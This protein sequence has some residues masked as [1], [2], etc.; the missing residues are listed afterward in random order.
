MSLNTMHDLLV[1]ELRDLY[2]AEGQVLKA[3]PTMAEKAN[4]RSLVSALT[5]HLHETEEH[6]TRLEECFELLAVSSKGKRCKGM[7]GLLT[8]A[9]ELVGEA[10]NSEV[11]DAAIISA[12]QKVEHYEICGYGT[13]CAF[14]ERLELSEVASLLQQILEE[15]SAANERLSEIAEAEVNV[16]TVETN[17]EPAEAEE[18]TAEG[19]RSKPKSRSPQRATGSRKRS[20]ASS[21]RH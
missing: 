1:H 6:Q 13:A 16:V 11:R 17:G 3:L 8:E 9:S 10:E 5:K 12:C 19:S 7:E 14:A 4:N 20:G 18:R 21:R 2:N 15:E